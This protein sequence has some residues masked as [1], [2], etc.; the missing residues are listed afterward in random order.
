MDLKDNPLDPLLKQAVGECSNEMQCKKCATSVLR[1]VRQQA[2]DEEKEREIQMQKKKSE[3]NLERNFC[4]NC[5][6]L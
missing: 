2:A 3:H 1:Y 6:Y 5:V 4:R